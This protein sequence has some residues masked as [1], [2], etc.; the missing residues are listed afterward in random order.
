MVTL[1]ETN[2]PKQDPQTT[3]QLEKLQ[4]EIADLRWKV[5]WV[6][7]VAQATSIIVAIVAVFAFLWNLYQFNT[8]QKV[9]AAAAAEAKVKENE[10]I[11]RELEKPVREKQLDLALELS[12]VAAT[13]TARLPKDKERKKAEIRLKELY[14]GQAIFIEDDPMR[15]KLIEF[16]NCVDGKAGCASEE[17]R[18]F[19]LTKLSE[20]LTN[21]CRGSVGSAWQIEQLESYKDDNPV[22]P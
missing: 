9:N 21:R 5:R 4:L 12:N 22:L 1:D 6:Y 3:A 13:I 11:I 16:V 8:Q 15:S 19:L 7:K 20:Q 10:A 14:W 17:D 2:D 18:T